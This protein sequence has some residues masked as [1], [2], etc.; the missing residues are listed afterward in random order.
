M[1]VEGR[2]ALVTGAS[3]G[4]GAGIAR[5]MAQE[6]AAV[7]VNYVQSEALANEVVKE[8][9]GGGGSAIAIQ[10]DVGNYA[11]VKS[12]VERSIAEFGKVD[13]LVNNAGIAGP[14]VPMAD[15]TPEEFEEVV[16]NHLIGSFNCTQCLL[17]HMRGLGRGDV[18][19]ISSRQTSFYPPNSSPYNAAK[20]GMD[21]LAQGLAKEERYNGIRVN[22][23]APGLVPTDILMKDLMET[24]GK[25]S[26]E[27]VDKVMPFGRMLRPEDIGNLCTFLASGQ[28]SHISGEVI[29]VRGAVGGEPPSFYVNGP[30]PYYA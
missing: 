13:I 27:E 3:R 25:S 16:R 11:Q 30:K 20:G 26:V 23:V 4:I 21:G 1:R 2:V 7:V 10:A 17:H 24:T 29:Y 14:S 28:G 6:G 19:F 9:R 8:I 12:M 22:V 18:I 15:V 5:C